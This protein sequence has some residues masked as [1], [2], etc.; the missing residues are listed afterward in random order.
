MVLPFRLLLAMLSR[1]QD[2]GRHAGADAETWLRTVRAVDLKGGRRCG[3]APGNK[4]SGFGNTGPGPRLRSN[5][6]GIGPTPT[7]DRPETTA[8][9]RNG[10]PSFGLRKKV[11]LASI[12]L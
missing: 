2:S 6:N 9:G 12:N 5:V 10:P 4:T 3:P 7:P 1:S 8:P 11:E